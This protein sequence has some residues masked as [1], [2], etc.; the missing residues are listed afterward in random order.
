MGQIYE[1]V[2][3]EIV[4]FKEIYELLFKYTGRR[5]CLL[6]LPFGMAKIQATFL[7][8]LPHPPLTRDQVQSLKTDNVVSKTA[9]GLSDLGVKV[10]DMDLILPTYLESYRPGGRFA[11]V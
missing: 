11:D 9:Q 8:I 6:N 3:P 1:L 10:T 4:S 5:R 7:S 2:G